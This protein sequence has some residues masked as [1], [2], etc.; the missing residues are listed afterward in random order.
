MTASPTILIADP[1]EETRLALAEAV[2]RADPAARVIEAADGSALNRALA[3][4]PVDLL[5]VDVLLPQTNGA[6][7]RRWRETGNPQGLVVLVTDML[8]PRWS[9]T[10]RR[11]GA[12][13]VILKP[14]G[15]LHIGRLLA[16][17]RILSRSL[18][19]LVVD[20]GQATRTLVRKLLGQSHF[21]F[22]IREAAG[23]RDAVRLIERDP[24]DLAIIEMSLPDYPALEVACRI[25]DRR[26]ETRILM[27]GPRIEEGVQ[28]QLTTFGASGFLPKPFQFFDIDKAVHE[29]FGLWQPYLINALR[30][31]SLLDAGPTM[32][33]AV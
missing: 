15:D 33:Q 7:I 30:R 16:A 11:V 21:S 6:D 17:R 2:G 25:N 13:D 29:S 31:E 14:L 28:R 32:G 20:P 8:A 3:D 18:D 27:T 4:S 24:V 19:C 9:A 23:G 26:P 10:A 22:R 12:Y 5:F 1:D